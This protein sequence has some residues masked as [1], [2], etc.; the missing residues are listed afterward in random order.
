MITCGVGDELHSLFGHSAIHIYDPDNRIDR[1]YNY[2]TF[3]FETPNF[4]LKFAQGKLDYYL[5]VT[6]NNG[7]ERFAWPYQA[8]GR[9]VD[10]QVLNLTGGQRQQVF[11]YL[12]NNVLEENRYYQYDFFFDNC[13]TRIHDVFGEVVGESLELGDPEGEWEVTFRQMIW[14]YLEPQ[15]WSQFGIDLVLGSPIDVVMTRQETMF[16]P[17]YVY[18]IYQNSTV[19]GEPWVERNFSLS[20]Q[21]ATTGESGFFTPNIVF[22]ILFGF[23]MILA[24]LRW[25]KVGGYFDAV[26][27]TSMGLLGI[28]LILMWFATDHIATKANYNLLWA[29]PLHL[30]VPIALGWSRLQRH[31][32]RYYMVMA[33][34]MFGLILFWFMVPQELNPAFRPIIL[35]IA[36]RYF[37]LYRTTRSALVME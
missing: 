34:I 1:V 36:L 18:A 29:N 27:F 13:A 30:I 28:V 26:L 11:N 3:N 33:A 8:Y 25:N 15:P 23:A 5:S 9:S 37:H 12:E 2:G 14:R 35:A 22:W 20:P 31:L 10:V 16:H 7:L 32:N 24:L 17:D 21:L 19:A 4:Y 6:K